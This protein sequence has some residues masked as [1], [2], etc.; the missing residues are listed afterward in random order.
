MNAITVS[1]DK[2]N[3]PKHSLS[4]FFL[5]IKFDINF[6]PSF[7]IFLRNVILYS[8]FCYDKR[9]CGC[10]EVWVFSLCSVTKFI[11]FHTVNQWFLFGL[12]QITHSTL[13]YNDVKFQK[14][15]SSIW[16]K[17]TS[18]R[19]WRMSELWYHNIYFQIFI[20]HPSNI[21]LFLLLKTILADLL[22]PIHKYLYPKFISESVYC[23]CLKVIII[24]IK[25]IF[26][27]LRGEIQ[28][29]R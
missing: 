25:P 4:A 1:F 11:H 21:F 19:E 26:K 5:S 20:M 7:S 27:T 9:G 15:Y 10:Q 17:F 12:E 18:L 14:L 3:L 6:V 28:T 23:L 22:D 2:G 8:W 16:Q 29:S 24:I 13:A